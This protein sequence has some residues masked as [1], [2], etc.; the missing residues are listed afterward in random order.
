MKFNIFNAQVSFYRNLTDTGTAIT[1]H[2]FLNDRSQ[3]DLIN[4]I[5]Q[6]TDSTERRNLKKRLPFAT[7]SG[8]FKDRHATS[9][10]KHSELICVDVDHKDNTQCKI[11]GNALKRALAGTPYIAYIGKSVSGNGYFI[12]VRVSIHEIETEKII[13][14]HRRIFES[15]KQD[16][17]NLGIMIDNTPDVC[18][19]RFISQDDAPYINDNATPYPM[20]RKRIVKPKPHYSR[21]KHYGGDN[22]TLQKVDRLC[23]IIQA[24]GIDLTQYYNDWV[25]IGLSLASLGEA[26]RKYYHIVCANFIGR[27]GKKYSP[28]ETNRK[29]DNFLATRNGRKTIAS[30]FHVCKRAGIE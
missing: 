6:T 22:D 17:L 7:I 1:L 5:R 23:G 15:L 2:E 24:K 18:R 27:N 29:F 10:I 25:G 19:M 11:W 14:E 21:F 28:E 20:V 12:I 13:D 30:F 8:V 16:F 3:D 9:L 26:G 4:R